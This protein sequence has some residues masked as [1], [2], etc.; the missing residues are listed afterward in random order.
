MFVTGV[1]NSL[2]KVFCKKSTDTSGP[3]NLLKIYFHCMLFPV[4]FSKCCRTANFQ[5]TRGRMFRD[6]K[7]LYIARALFT[8]G[9]LSQQN[10]Q[11]IHNLRHW[12]WKILVFFLYICLIFMNSLR[13]TLEPRRQPEGSYQVGF[14]RP[15]VLPPVP[16]SRQFLGIA[17]LAFSKFL[18]DATNPYEIVRDSRILWKKFFS[19]KIWENGPNGSKMG[20][21]QGFLNL[22]E[23]FG[24]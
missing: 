12:H 14:I 20:Q 7:L 11:L 19:L 1:L 18:H 22:I 16:L 8:L 21:K 5:S 24:H 2:Q 3:P 15:S 9:S 23:T 6:T 13:L 17:S 4:N 10:Y